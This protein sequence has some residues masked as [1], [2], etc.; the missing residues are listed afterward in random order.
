MPEERA[1]ISQPS[2]TLAA[3]TC[4]THGALLPSPLSGAHSVAAPRRRLN[5]YAVRRRR[6]NVAR[7]SPVLALLTCVSSAAL[8]AFVTRTGR[9]RAHGILCRLVDSACGGGGALHT[10]P[11]RFTRPAGFAAALARADVPQ[12]RSTCLA[13]LL[14]VP[15]RCGPPHSSRLA[16]VHTPAPVPHYPSLLSSV[17]VCC[18]LQAWWVL[19]HPC[20]KRCLYRRAVLRR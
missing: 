5:G 16:T 8:S 12:P 18:G 4:P 1:N 13:T 15:D 6:G 20:K 10:M 17:V 19:H 3:P 11:T 14:A 2:A 9:R 7:H